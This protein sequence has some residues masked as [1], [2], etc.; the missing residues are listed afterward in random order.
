[1]ETQPGVRF[2]SEF[3]GRVKVIACLD[4]MPNM[5]DTDQMPVHG[6][7]VGEREALMRAAGA[8]ENDV[9][10][11]VWGEAGDVKTA[12]E[13][14]KLRAIDALDGVPHETRQAFADGHTE[15]ERIL[16]GA[17]RMYPDTDTPPYPIPESLIDELSKDLPEYPWDRAA[18]WI[19]KGIPEHL[20]ERLSISMY[21]DLLDRLI[22]EDKFKP[23]FIASA[24]HDTLKNGARSLD[25][26]S[27][28][29]EIPEEELEGA[30]SYLAE[31]KI[32]KTG[33]KE[34][35]SQ[36]F[37]GQM[38][39]DEALEKLGYTQRKPDD[40]ER[41][42]DD[43]IR[44]ME[45]GADEW[46]QRKIMKRIMPSVRGTMDGATLREALRTRMKSA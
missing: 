4:Q 16:P 33:L 2:R 7:T 46:T 29:H 32:G 43:V 8:G 5:I 44:S 17:D 9:V 28:A 27:K 24:I 45:P 3:W 30:F 38:G 25:S 11:V 12:M 42:L 18:R 36:M 23:A 13:E 39:A 1:M 19:K 21:A 31:G 14:L 34:M 35:I 41:I 37:T 22:G 6:V 40:V 20:A 26:A 10:I 15:F